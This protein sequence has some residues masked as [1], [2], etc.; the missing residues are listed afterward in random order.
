MLRTPVFLTF[1]ERLVA[2]VPHPREH[3]W[4]YLGVHAPASPLRDP[5]VARRTVR[6]QLG[7]LIHRAAAPLPD[8]RVPG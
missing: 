8:H 7:S 4:A 2:L 3:Q 5:A 6:W 1:L